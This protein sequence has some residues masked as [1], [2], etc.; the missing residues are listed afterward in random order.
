MKRK[1]VVFLIVG[2][3]FVSAFGGVAA[4]FGTGP[5]S[6]TTESLIQAPQNHAQ[7]APIIV[8]KAPP[9]GQNGPKPGDPPGGGA[10]TNGNSWGG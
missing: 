2:L 4:L 5:T 8:A 3:T 1:V 7:M 10:T 6:A 9:L